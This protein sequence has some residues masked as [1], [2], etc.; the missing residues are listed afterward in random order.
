[1][2]GRAGGSSIALLVFRTPVTLVG[3]KLHAGKG[4]LGGPGGGGQTA[5]QGGAEGKGNGT[6]APGC[7][8]GVG[9][10][11]G[12]GAGGNGGAGGSS[13]DFAYAGV[14]PIIDGS[15]I[16]VA[17]SFANQGWTLSQSTS[18]GG[19]AGVGGQKVVPASEAGQAGRAGPPGEI[20][21]VAPLL[22]KP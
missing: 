8:G 3:S 5:Q 16:S 11:G 10:H 15:Q 18:A 12:G 7:A 9:G 22:E 1:M 13:I 19:V 6:L 17:D 4:G 21:A 2:G 14:A 20:Q